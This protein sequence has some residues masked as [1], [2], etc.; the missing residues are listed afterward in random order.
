MAVVSITNKSTIQNLRPLDPGRDF[1][2]VADLVELCFSDTMDPDGQDYLRQMRETARNAHLWGWAYTLAEQGGSPPGGFVWDEGGGI[3]GNLSLYPFNSQRHNCYLI[4]NVAVHP[5]Y[6]GRGIGRALTERALEYIK[7]RHA[8]AWLQ[9]RDDNPVA[10]W[11]YQSLGFTERARRTTW[12]NGSSA[13]PATIPAGLTIGLRRSQHWSQQQ[14]WLRRLYP[15]EL[16]WH[17]PLN[18]RMLP[19]DLVG[20]VYRLLTVEFP[21]HW[22]VQ[23]GDYLLGALTWQQTHGY[24]DTLWLATPPNFEMSAIQA[25]V[26]SA[27]QQLS[28]R[29]KLVLNFPAGLASQAIEAAGFYARNTLLWMSVE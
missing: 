21:R 7:R 24:A 9:V 12:Y 19:P 17:L 3:I 20:T 29:R 28:P 5:D 25:L 10:I 27:R 16:A 15:P 22:V 13:A 4:A 23:R 6:R 8:H 11:L 26:A 18:W 2:G 14:D 1:D